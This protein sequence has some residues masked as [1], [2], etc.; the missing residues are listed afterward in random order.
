MGGEYIEEPAGDKTLCRGA[1]VKLFLRCFAMPAPISRR[2]FLA[3]AGGA[4]AALGATP[5]SISARPPLDLLIRGGVVADGTGAPRFSAD[6]GVREGKIVAIGVLGDAVDAVT[7][8]EAAGLVVAPGFIDIHG[9]TDLGFFVDN[10]ADS[11]VRQ[12]ITTELAGA[13]GSSVMPVTDRMRA[14]RR[15]DYRER[16]GVDL[17]PGTWEELFRALAARGMLTNW[18]TMVGSGTVRE[19]V[20]GYE[21]RPA[22]ADEL[23]RMVALVEAARAAGA[24]GVSS[25]LEYTPNAFATPE[26][27]AA[28]ARPFADAALPYA[29]HMRNEAD[30]VQEAI[31]ESIA[32]A[33]AAGVPLQVSHVKAQGKRNWGESAEIL[34][35]IEREAA[36]RPTRFDVYPYTAYSTGLSSLFPPAAREGGTDVFLTRL[37]DLAVRAA[38]DE[39]IVM[40]GDWD[41]IQ[42][43]SVAGD[44]PKDVVGRRL[45]EYAAEKGRDPYDVTVELLTSSKNRISIVGHGMA[46]EDVE[47]FLAHPLGAYCS[48]AS[49]RSTEG[50][51]SEGVPHPRAYGAFPR[52]LGRYVREQQT[53]PLEEA[54]R[55]ATALP[56]E[57]LHLEDRGVIALGKAAD[58]VV[59]D[60]ATVADTATFEA[61][62]SYPVGIPHVI[63]NGELAVR[64]GTP[65][66]ALAGRVLTPV[67]D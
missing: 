19:V 7:V 52:L 35:T 22:T 67:S 15:D 24:V 18:V 54:V 53:L 6:V 46:E 12:G 14:E 36:E 57:I 3:A 58:L 55:K 43:A 5:R 59:F 40:M 26:E 28:L 38:V 2:T 45:G 51:L 41:T 65:A 62:H 29:T 44:A 11:K 4:A 32:I 30:Q 63:V 21:D 1:A 64:D 34:A 56:A 25:G 23:A 10:R 20:I 47:R 33:R 39:K 17:D 48:D 16:H 61:P 50:P 66:G 37:A 42:I 60:P 8:I 9:H 27:L 13:D 31:A 49:A